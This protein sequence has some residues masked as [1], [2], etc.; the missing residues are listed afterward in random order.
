MDKSRKKVKLKGFLFF[1][2][3]I[4]F[5]GIFIGQGTY[6]FIIYLLGIKAHADVMYIFIIISWILLFLYRR[7][8]IALILKKKEKNIENKK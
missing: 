6:L 7:I 2:L 8:I 3:L 4:I 1:S 5:S